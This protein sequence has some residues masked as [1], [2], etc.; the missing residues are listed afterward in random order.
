MIRDEIEDKIQLETI[1]INKTIVNMRRGTESKEK[2][3]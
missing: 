2:I 1:N 3:N